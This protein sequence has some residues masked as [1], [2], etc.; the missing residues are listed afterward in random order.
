MNGP[1]GH[2]QE[3]SNVWRT[4]KLERLE[5]DF[6]RLGAFCQGSKTPILTR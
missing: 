6:W 1:E 5:E 2:E 4:T 3:D